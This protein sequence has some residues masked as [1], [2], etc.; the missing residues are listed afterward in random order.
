MYHLISQTVIS[1]S[2]FYWTYNN[3]FWYA[4]VC[5]VAILQ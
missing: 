4:F 2:T 5:F 1:L 3:R